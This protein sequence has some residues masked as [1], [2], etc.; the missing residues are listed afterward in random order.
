MFRD[1][2]FLVVDD[3]DI[4]RIFL[5]TQLAELGAQVTEAASGVEAVEN[6]RTRYFDLIFLDLR[7]P[8]ISGFDVMR[9]I[10]RDSRAVN[11]E[12]PVI[13]VTA[14]ALPQQRR[15]ILEAGFCDCLIKPILEDQL[16]RVL[17]TWLHTKRDQPPCAP[18]PCTNTVELYLQAIIEKTGGNRRVAGILM[19]KLAEELPEQLADVEKALNK[20]DYHLAR[21]ITHK[22]NGS[23]SFCGLLGIRKAANE[24]ETA[25]TTASSKDTLRDRFQAMGSEIRAFLSKKT[26]FVAASNNSQ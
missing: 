18:L 23:A 9:V 2:N 13:A 24:L 21:E 8:G 22:I 26:N 5:K 15:Q 16:L 7:M 11:G 14:H 6:I 4:N 25:L 20:D 19:A 17:E 10:R 1:K 3:N 12:T